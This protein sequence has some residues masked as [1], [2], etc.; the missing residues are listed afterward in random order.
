[1][2]KVFFY[3]NYNP[4]MD[5]FHEEDFNIPFLG[6]NLFD[7]LKSSYTRFAN[8]L[9]FDICF[10]SSSYWSDD[11]PVYTNILEELGEDYCLFVLTDAFSLPI[12]DFTKDDYHFLA[13]N[14][15]KVFSHETG[16]KIGYINKNVD[17]NKIH[18]DLTGFKNIVKMSQGNFL[19]LNQTLVNNFT[20]KTVIPGN[21]GNPVILSSQDKIHDSRILGPS[22]IGEDV[23]IVKSVIYPGSIVM[24]N[25]TIINS[26]IF[27]SFICESSITDSSIKN[28]ISAL[29]FI[30]AMNLENSI[31][32]SGSVLNNGRKR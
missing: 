6:S 21:Y 20:S 29:S 8:L 11:I 30:D 14:P 2:I 16:I 17:F 13:Q 27:E 23:K 7:F 19:S 28:S 3:D 22:F 26:E 1:M 24:G 4:I 12:F 18:N 25:C 15:N 10:Y 32:P 31:I 9:G 5:Y